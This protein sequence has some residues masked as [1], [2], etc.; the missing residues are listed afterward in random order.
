MSDKNF[1][2]NLKEKETALIDVIASFISHTSIR[3][4]D[5]V[6]AKLEEMRASETEERALQIYD[7]MFE[8]RY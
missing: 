4:P 7:L 3:L 8:Y 6:I 1:D 2:K 5:D